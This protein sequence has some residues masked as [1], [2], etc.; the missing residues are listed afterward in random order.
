MG[1]ISS[2]TPTQ[3][4]VMEYLR[5]GHRARTEYLGVVYVNGGKICN[6]PTMYALERRGLVQRTGRN[7]WMATKAG[8]EL[9]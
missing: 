7:E 6:E 5:G 2:L 4:R 8:K 9:E 1:R 3:Q